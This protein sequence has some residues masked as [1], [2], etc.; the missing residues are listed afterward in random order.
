MNYKKIAQI[1]NVGIGTVSRYFNN[2]SISKKSIKKISKVIEQYNFKPNFRV[3]M[4]NRIDRTIYIVTTSLSESFV[5][6]IIEGLK[7]KIN[8]NQQ[9]VIIKSSLNSND[10]LKNLKDLMKQKPEKLLL[11]LPKLNDKITNYIQSLNNVFVVTYGKKI[12]NVY[13]VYVDETKAIKNLTEKYLSVIKPEKI[14]WIGKSTTDLTTGK[15]RLEAFQNV[16][17]K[18]G[19]KSK[20]FLVDNNHPQIIKQAFQSAQKQGFKDIICGTHTIFMTCSLLNCDPNLK[21]TD[22][23]Y[24]SFLDSEK[25]YIFKVFIDFFLIGITIANIF[26]G[27]IQKLENEIN[28]KII[29]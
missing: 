29:E 15:E 5:D 22:I 6:D 24:S 19:T 7:Y 1:A 27:E 28:T 9:L 20:S 3:L 14:A 12:A 2:G 23:G 25:A 13:S 21:L 18:H 11:F 26:K 4:R 16:V 10:Y 17:K 8:P